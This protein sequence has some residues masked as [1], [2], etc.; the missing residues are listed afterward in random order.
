VIAPALVRIRQIVVTPGGAGIRSARIPA[1]EWGPASQPSAI[2]S[3]RRARTW[4]TTSGGV[5]FGFDRGRL[6][7]GSSAV[8]PPARHAAISWDTRG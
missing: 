6:D 7:F 5:A 8:Q 1:I 3:A 4:S 2:S